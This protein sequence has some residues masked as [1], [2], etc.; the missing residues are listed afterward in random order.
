MKILEKK[1]QELTFD[2]IVSSCLNEDKT[3]DLSEDDRMEMV[4]EMDTLHL[5]FQH[6]RKSTN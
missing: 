3:K 1:K 6:L 4:I 2:L 5:E